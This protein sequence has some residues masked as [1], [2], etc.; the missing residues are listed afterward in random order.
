[1]FK[2]EMHE[3]ETEIL[4][5][6]ISKKEYFANELIIELEKQKIIINKAIVEMLKEAD[7]IAKNKMPSASFDEIFGTDN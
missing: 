6:L 3:F 1:M 2:K 5:E 4:K 7:L